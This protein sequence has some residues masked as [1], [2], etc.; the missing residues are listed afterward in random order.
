MKKGIAVNNPLNSYTVGIGEFSVI[1]S[2][3]F[4]SL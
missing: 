1:D 4:L 3:M 2:G